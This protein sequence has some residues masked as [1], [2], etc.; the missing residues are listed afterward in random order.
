MT[1]R[2]R[3]LVP[4]LGLLVLGTASQAS[5]GSTQTADCAR[6]P[7]TVGSGPPDWPRGALVAGPLGVFRHPLAQMTET[8]NGQLIAKMPVLVDGHAEVRLR[9]PPRQRNRVFLYYGRM[10]D[11]EGHPTTLIGRARGFSEVAFE[12]CA[13]R[14]RTVWPGG[15]RVRGRRAVRLSVILGVRQDPIPLRLGRPRPYPAR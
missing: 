8:A 2:L 10:R 5:A 1:L 11:R 3:W 14:T 15:I 7:I 12:P 13:D 9:V 6:G 4:V